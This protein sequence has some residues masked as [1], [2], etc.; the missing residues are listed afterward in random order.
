MENT[1]V[2]YKDKELIVHEFNMSHAKGGRLSKFWVEDIKSGREYLVKGSMYFS[3]EP[4]SEKIAYII[5]KNLGIDC[6][7]YD[8]IPSKLFKGMIKTNPMCKYLSLC[9]KIDRKN[10]SI[11]SVAEIKR[12]RNLVKDTDEEPITNRQV[13]YE[14]LDQKYIDT[15]ILFDAIIG[16]VDRHY[17]N[18][19]IL[20]S[21]DGE[22]VGAPLLDH[23]ASVLAQSPEIINFILGAKTAKFLNTSSMVEKTHDKQIEYISSINGISFNIVPKTIQ[24]LNELEPTFELIPKFRREAVKQYVVY[25]LHKYLGYIK[26]E[27]RA[28]NSRPDISGVI[29][30]KEH[31]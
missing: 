21:K 12:A 14:I 4:F 30:E 6:L 5:G 10:Y 16:N 9:E 29:K 24:I 20:R 18:V 7:E 11:T 26:Q 25:R 27:G 28:I 2:S 22:L 13:M 3:Y 8:I 19:H 15:M 31:T 23:G 17:G 1:I